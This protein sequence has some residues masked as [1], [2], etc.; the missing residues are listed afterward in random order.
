MHVGAIVG[1]WSLRPM[2]QNAVQPAIYIYISRVCE[3][4]SN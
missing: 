2:D 1:R 3:G 4:T